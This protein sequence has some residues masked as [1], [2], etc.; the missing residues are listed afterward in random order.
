MRTPSEGV[1]GGGVK[2]KLQNKSGSS[3]MATMATSGFCVSIVAKLRVAADFSYHTVSGLPRGTVRATACSNLQTEA[4]KCDMHGSCFTGVR[5]NQGRRRVPPPP[6]PEPLRPN[7]WMQNIIVIRYSWGGF[8]SANKL[9][10]KG[11][12]NIRG[13]KTPDQARFGVERT[14]RPA[15]LSYH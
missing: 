8:E 9:Q 15:C 12:G 13:P 2:Q 5:V 4:L 7:G 10:K 3:K 6:A 14:R 11:D 1:C